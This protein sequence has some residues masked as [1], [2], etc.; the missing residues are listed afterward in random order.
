MRSFPTHVVIR[1]VGLRDGLQ[2]IQAV[3]PT[4]RKLEWIAGA[5]A[6]GQREIEVG[7]FVPARLLPQ[8]ADTAELV[9]YAK[10]LPGLAVSVLVPNLKGAQRALETG[11]DLLLVPLSASREH[12]LANLRKTPDEVVAEVARI[13]AERDAAGST[14]LIEGG[15]GTAFGCTIQGRVEPDEVLRC[16][17]ALLDAGADRVSIADTV[18]YAGPAAVRALFERARRVAGE[19]FFCGHFHDTRGLALAN[20]YAALETGVARFD[21]TLAGIGGCP[22]APGASGNAASEDLAF[23]LADMGIDTGIDLPALLALRAKVARWLDGE[24][25]HGAL[26]RAGLPKTHRASIALNA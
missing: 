21:A 26:W 25:L 19:R 15:I 7:S 22:H 20:V 17:Q 3:L 12:S 18:G 24:S 23:M 2:S 9:A 4:A 6:A 8:L 13:R 16:M 1:E 14:T 10:T 11:A 5:Y